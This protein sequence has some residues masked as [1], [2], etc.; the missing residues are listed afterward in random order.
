MLMDNMLTLYIEVIAKILKKLKFR[1]TGTGFELSFDTG[2]EAS[3]DERIIKIDQARANLVD[4]LKAIDELRT[5]AEENKKEAQIA[6]EQLAQLV[7]VKG[8]K[9]HFSFDNL[10]I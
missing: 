3:I 1:F 8:S 10:K 4:G 9:L 6:L 2:T 5:S 7:K